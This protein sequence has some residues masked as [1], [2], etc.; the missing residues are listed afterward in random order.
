MPTERIVTPIKKVR[1]WVTISSF[2][3]YGTTLYAR[4]GELAARA[5]TF[6]SVERSPPLH[7]SLHFSFGL[8]KLNEKQLARLVTTRKN[9][10]R[11]RP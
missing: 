10:Q 5:P 8:A 2:L 4:G 1:E 3:V 7:R 11:A 6:W 9:K